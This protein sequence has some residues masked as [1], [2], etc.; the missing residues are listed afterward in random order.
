MAL[1]FQLWAFLRRDSIAAG[2]ARLALAWQA[3]G[4]GFTA[5][6]LYYLGRLVPAPDPAP[7][8][9][10][11]YFAFALVG[12]ALFGFLVSVMRACPSALRQEQVAGTLEGLAAMPCAVGTLALGL[13]LWPALLGLGQAALT[14]WVGEAVFGLPIARANLAAS[15][16]VLGLSGAAFLAVGWL[17]AAYVL[18]TRQPDPLTG[19]VAAASALVGGLFYPTTVLPA[20]LQRLGEWL[21]MTHALRAMRLVLLEGTGAAGLR[22]EVLV[23]AAFAAALVPLGLLALRWS[24]AEARRAGTLSAY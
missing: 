3:A 9:P 22:G 18:L 2:T 13:S 21:P 14:L 20:P 11:G 10:A 15:L 8:R 4:V 7:G 17:A 12:V 1:L 19:P 23:L 6:T 16:V 5:A 24:F